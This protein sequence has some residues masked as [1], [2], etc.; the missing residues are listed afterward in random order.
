MPAVKSAPNSPHVARRSYL[1]T[2]LVKH[3]ASKGALATSTSAQYPRHLPVAL[4]VAMAVSSLGTGCVT[5]PPISIQPSRAVYG[6]VVDARYRGADGDLV[7]EQRVYRTVGAALSAAPDSS[8]APFVVL[9]RNGR[10]HEKLSIDKA[11][12]TLR[13]ESRD[14]TI[15]TN[16]ASADTPDSAGGTYGPRRSFTLRVIAPD[17]RAEHLTIE[18]AF[19]FRGNLARAEGDPAKMKNTQAVALHLDRGS[20]RTAVVDCILIGWQGTLYADAGRAWFHDSIILGQ[21]DFIFGGGVALFDDCDIVSRGAGYI[22]APS[23][24]PLQRFGFVFIGSRLGRES[25]A[26]RKNTVALGRP[27]H[28]SSNPSVNPS[29]VYIDCNLDDH[30]LK[31][32]WAPMGGYAPETARFFEYRDHGVGAA[33]HPARRLLSDVEAVRYS[34]SDVLAA[35]NPSPR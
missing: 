4:V 35:W 11:N 25:Q 13:G 28:P 19:N 14:S 10:Y 27:W 8:I 24:P 17:F 5:P 21:T 32:G 7:G 26:V 23:T 33:K 34:P 9:I 1:T 30:I 15:L 2:R 6:A 29:V 18:N 12:I 3:L 22:T 16:D 20:D 31:E